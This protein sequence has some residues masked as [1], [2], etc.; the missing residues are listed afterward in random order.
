[1]SDAQE[2]VFVPGSGT[3]EGVRKRGAVADDSSQLTNEKS[4]QVS[5]LFSYCNSCITVYLFIYWHTSVQFINIHLFIFSITL[6]F[7]GNL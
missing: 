5:T 1:M 2:Q 6:F 4:E 3:T 7:L